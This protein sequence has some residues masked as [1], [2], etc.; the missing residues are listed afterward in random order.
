M[1]RPLRPGVCLGDVGDIAAFADNLFDREMPE[2]SH[3][4]KLRRK[5]WEWQ[6]IA[7]QSER[8]GLLNRHTMGVGLGVGAEALIFFFARH[9]GKIIATDLYS[10]ET[11]WREACYDDF[12]AIIAQAPLSFDRQRLQIINADMRD[13]PVGDGSV[14]LVWSTS[15]IEHVPTFAD[16]LQTLEEISRVLKP[17]GYAILTT[18]Y[19]LSEPPYLLPGVNALDAVSLKPLL[20][21][22]GN[23]L[24]IVGD[25]DLAFDWANPANGAAPRRYIKEESVP[26]LRRDYVDGHK[27]GHMAHPV[28]MSVICPMALTLRRTR[29]PAPLRLPLK[30]LSLPQETAWYCAA[31]QAYHSGENTVAARGFARVVSSPATPHQLRLHAFRF[32]MDAEIRLGLPVKEAALRIA[33]MLADASAAMLRDDDCGDFFSYILREGG[34]SEKA[35]Q[36]A[37]AA[38]TSPS[39]TFDHALR[40]GCRLFSCDATAGDVVAEVLVDLIVNGWSPSVIQAEFSRAAGAEGVAEAVGALVHAVEA[41]LNRRRDAFGVHLNSTDSQSGILKVSSS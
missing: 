16:L 8:L 27:A 39:A 11:A 23:H 19:C 22:L 12:A 20:A 4:R 35:A 9:C 32:G 2:D 33:L 30:A 1:T 41:E 37:R 6:Y 13:I 36:V 5:W 34:L 3:L 29:D 14:D 7:D 18:E 24:E 10:S 38:A 21:A 28:G 15:S 26:Y 40:M 25:T 31:M 17:G